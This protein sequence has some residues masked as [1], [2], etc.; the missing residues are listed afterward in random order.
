MFELAR[1]VDCVHHNLAESIR[2]H[3]NTRADF[4]VTGLVAWDGRS[5]RRRA[6]YVP[7]LSASRRIQ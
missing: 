2:Q 7:V 1:A 5:A 6:V 4:G 3:L